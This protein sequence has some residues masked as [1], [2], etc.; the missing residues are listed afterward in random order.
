MSTPGMSAKKKT[1]T[2]ATTTTTTE[3]VSKDV[4]Y[5]PVEIIFNMLLYVPAKDLHE[6]ARYVC[7]QW[8]DIVSDPD[9]ITTHCRM[10]STN[11]F[12]IQHS[13]QLHKASHIELHI[14]MGTLVRHETPVEIPFRGAIVCCFNGLLVLLSGSRTVDGKIGYDVFYVVNPVTKVIISLPHLTDSQHVT[15]GISLAVDSSGHYKVVHV[16]GKTDYYEQVK[17]RVFT[18]GV[19]KAWRFIDLQGI[20]AVN[21]RGMRFHSFCFGGFMYWFT[22]YTSYDISPFGFALDVDT[23]IIYPLSM[24]NDVIKT[25]YPISIS[26]GT[27]PGLV[28]EQDDIWRAWKLTDVKSSEWTELTRINMRQVYNQIKNE[29]RTSRFWNICPFRLFNGHLWLRCRREVNNYVVVHYDLARERFKHFRIKRLFNHTLHP[30]A[31]T[32][33]SPKN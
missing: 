21:A 11:S 9:F 27:G 10:S 31:N 17:M 19:D 29:F 24:P 1:V 22:Y 2:V 32:L 26:M 6:V 33:V 13:E 23:E 8:Y 25:Q 30:H 3:A 16:S 28:T 5:L 20:P 4:P 12:L 14:L 7:K 18:I 15:E